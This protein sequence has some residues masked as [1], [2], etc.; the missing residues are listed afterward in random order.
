MQTD[1]VAAK[2]YNEFQ[3]YREREKNSGFRVVPSLIDVVVASL[4]DDL[5]RFEAYHGSENS[6]E[7][8]LAAFLV[9]W[10]SKIKPIAIQPT[11][12]HSR[13]IAINEIFGFILAMKI[14]NIEDAARVSDDFFDEFVYGLYYRNVDP[15]QM[16]FTFRMLDTLNKSM[17]EGVEIV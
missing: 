12:K 2:I 13:Q 9:Y 5:R 16:F 3:R 6:E 14:L 4:D 11:H 15:R 8:K 1:A 7:P 10:M 17:P